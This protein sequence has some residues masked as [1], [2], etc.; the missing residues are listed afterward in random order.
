MQ[1][2]N[3]QLIPFSP[4]VGRRLCLNSVVLRRCLCL[5]SCLSLGP[6]RMLLPWMVA[7]FPRPKHCCGRS[8]HAT[9]GPAAARCVDGGSRTCFITV[10]ASWTSRAAFFAFRGAPARPPSRSSWTSRGSGGPAGPRPGAAA[11][12]PPWTSSGASGSSNARPTGP[13]LPGPPSSPST[14]PLAGDPADP[15]PDAVECRNLKAHPCEQRLPGL[16]RLICHVSFSSNACFSKAPRS[17]SAAPPGR[18][19]LLPCGPSTPPGLTTRPS[20]L[21][22]GFFGCYCPVCFSTGLPSPSGVPG[23]WI[24]KPAGGRHCLSPPLRAFQLQPVSTGAP[25]PAALADPARRAERAVRLVGQGELSAT[26]SAL[27]S[28]P[29]APLTPATLAELQDPAR[30]PDN[31]CLPFVRQFY[32]DP[33]GLFGMTLTARPT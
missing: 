20:R 8:A 1:N 2:A 17:S 26:S 16:T 5:G 12:S 29:L 28:G 9:G 7:V 3:G 27:V 22:R 23:F 6:C 4:S 11:R 19:C 10:L 13:G 25:P 21:D 18:P 24:S 33:S 32:S 15:M 30:R 14:A 31:V